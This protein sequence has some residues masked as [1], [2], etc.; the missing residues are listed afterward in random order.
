[1]RTPNPRADLEKACENKSAIKKGQVW[2]WSTA[3][4]ESF[5]ALMHVV[6]AKVGE[7][8]MANL[9]LRQGLQHYALLRPALF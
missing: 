3:S 9:A 2:K 1:M 8:A 5:N 7:C 6:F 4:I